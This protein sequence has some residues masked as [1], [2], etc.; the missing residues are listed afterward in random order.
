MTEDLEKE[1]PSVF[2]RISDKKYPFL[3]IYFCAFATK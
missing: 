1:G 2:W 3:T